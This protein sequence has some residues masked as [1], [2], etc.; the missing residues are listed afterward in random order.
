MLRQATQAVSHLRRGL[1]RAA[2]KQQQHQAAEQ[3]GVQQPALQARALRVLRGRQA[4]PL[5]PRDQ[6]GRR[7]RQARAGEQ[8]QEPHGRAV[9]AAQGR[10]C[11]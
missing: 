5:V 9:C 3:R 6:R 4:L 2:P 10:A 8:L 7:H 11:R 1:E